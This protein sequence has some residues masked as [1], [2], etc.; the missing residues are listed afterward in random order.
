[1][2]LDAAEDCAADSSYSTWQAG[3]SI[4][5]TDSVLPDQFAELFRS[6]QYRSPEVRLAIAV[7]EDAIRTF[8]RYRSWRNRKERQMFNEVEAWF[9]TPNEDGVFS[10]ENVCEVLRI[11]A[12]YIRR[13]LLQV[14]QRPRDGAA[15]ERSYRMVVASKSRIVPPRSASLT[16]GV[17]RRDRL[18]AAKRKSLQENRLMRKG[19]RR[20]WQNVSRSDF[21][22]ERR[23]S[24]A[25]PQS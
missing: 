12:G 22:N 4:F 9:F 7:L 1:M 21:A 19:M 5:Q 3:N 14:K 18:T 2:T 11:N 15:I 25:H 16:D 24:P 13:G 6:T 20:N 17:R 10:F 23:F 8:F